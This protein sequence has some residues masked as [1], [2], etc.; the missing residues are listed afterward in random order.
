LAGLCA[1]LLVCSSACGW[2]GRTAA[3]AEPEKK[4]AVEAKIPQPVEAVPPEHA[5]LMAAGLEIFRKDV[6]PLLSTRCLDCHSSASTTEGGFDLSTREGLLRGGKS[7]KVVVPGKSK[8]SRL[9]RLVAHLEKPHMPKDEE[10]LSDK[11]IARLAEWID[12]FA[13]YDGAFGEEDGSVKSWT[14]REPGE[15]AR[16]FWS[17]QPLR[18]AAAPSV[19]DPA[20]LRTPADNC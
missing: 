11:E 10:K 18:R 16:Q 8:E 15:K 5:R 2:I 4:P 9:V 13:P 3:A 6:R 20:R 19:S 17:F 7:G 12:C 14:E 1:W